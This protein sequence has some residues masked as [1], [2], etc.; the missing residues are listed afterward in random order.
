MYQL[1]HGTESMMMIS[2]SIFMP[3]NVMK[4]MSVP[5][6]NSLLNGD[7]VG[8]S[9]IWLVMYVLRRSLLLI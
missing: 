7:D 1:V 4:C 5:L 9:N 8:C 6:A 3:I 2:D